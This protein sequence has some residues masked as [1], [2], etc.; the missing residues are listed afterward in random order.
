MAT[1]TQD[2]IRDEVICAL[3]EVL[4]NSDVFTPEFLAEKFANF[5]SIKQAEFFNILANIVKRWPT[6]AIFQWAY[7]QDILTDEGKQLIS[8]MN[9]NKDKEDICN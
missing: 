5:D 1:T 8:Q 4:M 7:M 9:F 6:P 3:D 2:K